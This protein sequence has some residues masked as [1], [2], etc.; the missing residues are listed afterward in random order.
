MAEIG[1]GSPQSYFG[2]LVDVFK[3]TFEVC[4]V[5]PP[6]AIHLPQLGVFNN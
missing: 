1:F 4:Q 5:L 6:L 2:E 3:Y